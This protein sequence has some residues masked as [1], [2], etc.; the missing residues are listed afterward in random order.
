[1]HTVRPSL[2]AARR[3]RSMLRACAAGLGRAFAQIQD[4]SVSL[5]GGH[6]SQ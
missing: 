5:G 6:F 1:M 4:R 2:L 3:M